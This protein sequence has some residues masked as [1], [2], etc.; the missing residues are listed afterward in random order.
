MA[1]KVLPKGVWRKCWVCGVWKM[2][3]LSCSG[4]DY[5]HEFH[6]FVSQYFE[7][8]Y[9]V[10]HSV[11]L[12]TTRYIEQVLVKLLQFRSNCYDSVMHDIT[13]GAHLPVP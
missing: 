1:L 10:R 4:I 6:Q 8:V 3:G 12:W 9:I 7:I 11:E 2:V 5:H 13:S